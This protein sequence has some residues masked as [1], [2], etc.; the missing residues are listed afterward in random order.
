VARFVV[1]ILRGLK[2]SMISVQDAIRQGGIYGAGVQGLQTVLARNWPTGSM[3][4]WVGVFLAVMLLASL[5]SD[6]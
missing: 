5:L 3:V 2:R 4:L 1:A 6:L